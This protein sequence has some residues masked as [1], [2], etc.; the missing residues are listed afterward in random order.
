MNVRNTNLNLLVALDSL[1]AERSVTRAASKMGLSQPAMSHNLSQLR[2]LF[3]DP[4]VLRGG[5]L[6]PLAE[7]LRL[8]LGS[9]LEELQR[10]LNTRERFDPR[11]SERVFRIAVSD[12]FQVTSLHRLLAEVGSRAPGVSLV[13]RSPVG[14]LGR[15]L[16]SGE[17]DLVAGSAEQR[18]E[19]NLSS[20]QLYEDRF[21]C[22]LR[23]NH[24]QIEKR[25]TLAKYCKLSHVLVARDEEPGYVDHVLTS[26][27][28]TRRVAL[29]LPDFAGIGHVVAF[30]D[31]VATV[32]ERLARSLVRFLPLRWTPP[33]LTLASFGV[34]MY[35]HP[36][37]DA[38]PGHRWLRESLSQ[39][40]TM[41]R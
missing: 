30:S 39:L 11:S 34:F 21:A 32:P 36:R 38:E 13:L 15:A 24:P 37:F 31:L 1:L 8:P 28:R 9:G 3:G 6:T 5:A 7:T 29:R 26:M 18:P 40:G 12:S 16:A 41:S 27:G 14:D 35:W 10:V 17:L 4:L 25:L 19:G 33:P 20:Q 23:K 22:L 2:R